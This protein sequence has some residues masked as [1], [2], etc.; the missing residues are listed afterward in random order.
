[1]SEGPTIWTLGHSRHPIEKFIDLARRHRIVRIVD[2]RG[3]P[4]SRFNPQFNRKRLA[5]SL[6][7]A[8]IAYD[9]LGETLSGRPRDPAFR[10]D[11]GGVAWDR[12]RAW[13]ALHADLDRLVD[14]ARDTRL[15]L[16][17]AE[18]NPRQCHRR[19][20]LTPLL[21]AKGATVLHIRGDGRIEPEA[22][23]AATDTAQGDLFG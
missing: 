9:W 6:E 2:T 20:L 19:F 17:C 8:G 16:I 4:A 10:R 21:E 7:E 11:D 3:Q 15:A 12:L 23:L 5:A 13:P 22:D 18:E 1:M 14:E